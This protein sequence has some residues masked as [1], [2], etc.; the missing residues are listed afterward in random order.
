MTEQEFQTIIDR[1]K[2]IVSCM[3]DDLTPSIYDEIHFGNLHI[4]DGCFHF[5]YVAF[6][7]TGIVRE[8]LDWYEIDP[9]F[10]A[11]T[12]EEIDKYIK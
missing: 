5:R 6:L 1:D 11:A 10:R 2:C 3:N 9:Q 8:A 7:D 12:Q 4:K